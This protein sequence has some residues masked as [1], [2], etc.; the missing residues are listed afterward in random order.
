[1]TTARPSPARVHAAAPLL[2]DKPIP[3][4]LTEDERNRTLQHAA[5]E[6]R[7][8]SNFARL[9]FLRGMADYERSHPPSTAQ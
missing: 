4:R 7:S 2:H 3:L 6:G 9:M 5:D 8:A 1:M